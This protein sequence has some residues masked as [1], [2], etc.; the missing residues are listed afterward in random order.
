MH[1]SMLRLKLAFSIAMLTVGCGLDEVV[2]PLPS[3]QVEIEGVLTYG[4]DSLPAA[5]VVIYVVGQN[6]DRSSS[7]IHEGPKHTFGQDTTDVMG[8]YRVEFTVPNTEHCHDFRWFE[9]S[10][11]G[12]WLWG[13]GSWL[14]GYRWE[15]DPGLQVIDLHLPD[16]VPASLGS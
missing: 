14:S 9:F 15:C 8:R 7:G 16:Y 5:S 10:V 1:S 6:I 12:S 3:A 13:W 11:W 4:V 2:A